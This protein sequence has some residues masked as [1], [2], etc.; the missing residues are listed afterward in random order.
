MN[1]K[2]LFC[3]FFWKLPIVVESLRE[4]VITSYSIHYTKLYENTVNLLRLWSAEA[5]KSFDFAEFNIG[6]YFGAVHEKMLAENITKVLYPI[7]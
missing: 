6:D 5:P 2:I 4:A 3:L 7:V 1:L